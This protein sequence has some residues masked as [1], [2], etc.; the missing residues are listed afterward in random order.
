MLSWSVS[1]AS[2]HV[3]CIES[4]GVKIPSLSESQLVE[5]STKPSLLTSKLLNNPFSFRSDKPSL[6]LSKS[7]GF[8][9]LSAS[10]FGNKLYMLIGL[11]IAPLD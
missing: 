2:P 11:L 8:A 5:Q 1:K 7:Y 3:F 4:T 9:K 10:G 6:S